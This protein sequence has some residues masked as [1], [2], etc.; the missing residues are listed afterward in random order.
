MSRAS[1]VILKLYTGEYGRA[2]AVARSELLGI[3][4]PLCMIPHLGRPVGYRLPLLFVVT[5]QKPRLLPLDGQVIR[6]V[7]GINNLIERIA[8]RRLQASPDR[9]RPAVGPGIRTQRVV[10]DG[11]GVF[12]DRCDSRFLPREDS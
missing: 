6:L 10:Q 2:G 7:G 8:I 11:V 3:Q 12:F 4:N 9:W 1:P 5:N